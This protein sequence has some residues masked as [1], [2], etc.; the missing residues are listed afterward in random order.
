MGTSQSSDDKNSNG[1]GSRR[2]T[3]GDVN[4]QRN[5]DIPKIGRVMSAP[6]RPQS[7]KLDEFPDVQHLAS[8]DP[9]HHFSGWATK[10][11]NDD[12][13]GV[14]AVATATAN[15]A[16]ATI[17]AGADVC[18]LTLASKGVGV[19]DANKQLAPRVV[20][21]LV[22]Q[23][24]KR[25][26]CCV[27]YTSDL[28]SSKSEAILHDTKVEQQ[29]AVIQSECEYSLT[30]SSADHGKLA[31]LVSHL[32]DGNF[33]ELGKMAKFHGKRDPRLTADQQQQPVVAVTS[34]TPPRRKTLR[35]S[36]VRR[37]NESI[38]EFGANRLRTRRLKSVD[39][40]Y[41]IFDIPENFDPTKSTQENYAILVSIGMNGCFYG[42]RHV[43][44]MA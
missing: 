4:L 35:P 3:E 41:L 31:S 26:L 44:S 30:A 36:L 8:E 15:A 27:T 43:C 9:W 25:V 6:P 12:C 20:Q 19:F 18:P 32:S 37:R 42:V 39:S 11:I 14:F 5:Y 34:S 38:R 21:V 10:Q 29:I 1:S 28:D 16:G 23:S 22:L 40:A 2:D 17:N 13:W 33:G 24:K 7:S